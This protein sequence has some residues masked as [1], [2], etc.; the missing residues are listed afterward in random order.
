MRR[1]PYLLAVLVVT[2]AAGGVRAQ[3]AGTPV[4]GVWKAVDESWS[5]PDTA[6]TVT[7]QPAW[8][9]FV[10]NRYS[11]S[12]V[13]VNTPRPHFGRGKP[14]AKQKIQ[15]F[16]SFGSETGTFE[17]KGD[18]MITHSVLT[19]DG[20]AGRRGSFGYALHGDTMR[21]TFAVPSPKDSTK[22]GSFSVVEVRVK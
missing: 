1:P 13:Y 6:I 9:F 11:W 10:G 21:V 14:T 22:M 18:S 20:S 12:Y 2:V 3:S 8:F 5:A 16:N 17:L 15:A 4:E 7:P 19:L